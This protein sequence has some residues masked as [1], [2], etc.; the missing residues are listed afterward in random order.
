[1]SLA[2]RDWNDKSEMAAL[3]ISPAIFTQYDAGIYTPEQIQRI[4][5]QKRHLHQVLVS[6]INNEN[7]HRYAT[8]AQTAPRRSES[9]SKRNSMAV[10]HRADL[11]MAAS[12][13]P[14]SREPAPPMRHLRRR[15]EMPDQLCRFK[16][17]HYCRPFYEDRVYTS[18]ES[19]LDDTQAPISK[20]ETA[21]LRVLD[22]RVL[23][24][25]SYSPLRPANPTPFN[26]E[27]HDFALEGPYELSSEF[28]S[29]SLSSKG[30][31][32]S[33]GR[34]CLAAAEALDQP[35][36]YCSSPITSP[37]NSSLASP[38]SNLSSISLPL[39]PSSLRGWSSTPER[40]LLEPDNNSYANAQETG[41]HLMSN[42]SGDFSDRHSGERQTTSGAQKTTSYR[43]GRRL[44]NN[45]NSSSKTAHGPII[46]SDSDYSEEV[47]VDGGVALTEEGV[48]MRVP[49]VAT[50]TGQS[51]V[52]KQNTITPDRASSAQATTGHMR[53][54]TQS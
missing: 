54:C 41:F 14:R 48:G 17:C 21:G 39:T 35:H 6:E 13:A 10:P 15:S 44:D 23:K 32:A 47:M 49:D 8:A 20:S 50:R 11:A 27:T 28:S 37:T 26:T 40:D 5:D 22:A 18:F 51:L 19:A 2:P 36:L 45:E 33:L 24:K 16:C 3:G 4:K 29:L 43:Q 1:M 53:T 52:G 30:S 34:A 46:S 31:S 42:K 38:R 9:V 7:D 25:I 12:Q